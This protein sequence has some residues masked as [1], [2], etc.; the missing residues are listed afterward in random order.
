MSTKCK[1][2]YNTA[3]PTPYHQRSH[4]TIQL[5]H[6]IDLQIMAAAV[7]LPSLDHYL[8]SQLFFAVLAV[9]GWLQLVGFNTYDI[10]SKVRAVKK[11]TTYTCT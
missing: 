1:N 4:D 8:L 9:A 5:R 6:K 7:G 3:E 11:N 10:L 2:D